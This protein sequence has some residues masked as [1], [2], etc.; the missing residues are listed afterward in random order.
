MGETFKILQKVREQKPLIHHITNWVTIYDCANV[1]RTVGALPVMAHAEEE[2]ADMAVLASA[3]VLNIGTLTPTLVE[4]MKIA[5]LA[6]NAKKIPIILDAVGT[7]ATKLRDDK[8]AELLKEL[9]IDII[10]GNASEIAK[11]SGMD[12]YTKGV[13]AVKVEGNLQEIARKLAQQKEATVVITGK[14]DII[15]DGT[16][17]YLCNNG[18][19]MMGNIVGTGCM[20]TSVIGAFAA[21]EK[22]HARA[23]A[24]ALV[25]FGIA[26]EIAAKHSA[27]PG[28]FKQNFYDALYNLNEQEIEKLERLDKLQ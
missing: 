23:A 10:K 13:E 5:G 15:T 16:S 6:A 18:D 7:G 26:G 12:V 20:V 17:L 25:V 3:L 24:A 8:T 21:V 11:I 9:R 22:D 14:Q 28:T 4:A 19:A 1:V 2:A 27:G